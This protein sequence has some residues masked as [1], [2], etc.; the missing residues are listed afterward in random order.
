M[1]QTALS[2][3]QKAADET[4]DGRSLGGTGARDGDRGRERETSEEG[5]KRDQEERTGDQ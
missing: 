2:D 3:R 4:T 1:D 5:G